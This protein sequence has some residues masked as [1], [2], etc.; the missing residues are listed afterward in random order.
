[1]AQGPLPRMLDATRLPIH[2]AGWVYVLTNPSMP[3]LVKIGRTQ[4]P[5]PEKRMSSL[6]SATGVPTPFNAYGFVYALDCKD[7]ERR[8]H[9][10]L[11][12]RRPNPKREFFKVSPEEA[13]KLVN[14][15]AEVQRHHPETQLQLMLFAVSENDAQAVNEL[16]GLAP[17]TDVLDKSL[18]AALMAKAEEVAIALLDCGANPNTL[19]DGVGCYA[20]A[21]TED[22]ERVQR[23]LEQRNVEPCGTAILAALDQVYGGADCCEALDYIKQHRAFSHKVGKILFDR[24]ERLPFAITEWFLKLGAAP[25]YTD[26]LTGATLL[27]Q[28]CNSSLFVSQDD[29]VGEPDKGPSS[30]DDLV[31]L[32]LQHGANPNVRDANGRT[33][34]CIAAINQESEL[35]QLLLKGGAKGWLGDQD[36]HDPLYYYVKDLEFDPTYDCEESIYSTVAVDLIRSGCNPNILHLHKDSGEPISLLQAAIFIQDRTLIEACI[37]S[38]ADVFWESPTQRWSAIHWAAYRNDLQTIAHLTKSPLLFNRQDL[39]EKLLC[40]MD[41]GGDTALAF[42]IEGQASDAHAYLLDACSLLHELAPEDHKVVI[43]QPKAR[44]DH[45]NGHDCAGHNLRQQGEEIEHGR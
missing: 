24:I 22:L 44:K 3:G 34:I 10:S 40:S 18:V 27:H 43:W 6:G 36:G 9:L 7:C 45:V 26:Q 13:L 5:K 33:P 19:I 14:E 8:V 11:A 37:D 32:L 28:V 23:A 15:H 21:I 25:N 2:T 17:A 39:A 29:A 12:A 1:M 41:S 20:V 38:G 35:I 31:K 16:G 42:A 30:Q 4:E